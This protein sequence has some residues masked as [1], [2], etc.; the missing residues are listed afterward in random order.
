MRITFILRDTLYLLCP[1]Y[2]PL[3]NPLSWSSLT[4]HP[5]THTVF[6]NEVLIIFTRYLARKSNPCLLALLRESIYATFSYNF[7]IVVDTLHE[8]RE[9]CLTQVQSL[10][11]IATNDIHKYKTTHLIMSGHH[12]TLFKTYSASN[13]IV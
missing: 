4:F 13:G 7:T 11:I 10:N 1:I 9:K 5:S 3:A 12:H 6:R 8:N 2:L